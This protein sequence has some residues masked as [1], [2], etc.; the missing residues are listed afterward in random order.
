[1][2]DVPIT[3]SVYDFLLRLESKGLMEH[4]TLSKLPLQRKEII[5]ILKQVNNENKHFHFTK[6]E[7]ETANKYLFD[8]GYGDYSVVF[9]SETD[10]TQIF[11]KGLFDG[12]NKAFYRYNSRSLTTEVRPLAAIDYIN[13]TNADSS[14]YLIVGT[15]GLRWYGSFNDNFGFFLQATNGRDFSGD[16]SVAYGTEYMKSLKFAKLGSDIDLT[17]SHVTFESGWFRA[18]FGRQE[19]LSGAGLFQRPFVSTMSP[20]LD[21][22]SLS[23]NFSSF[24]YSY[25]FANLIGYATDTYST[26]FAAK[27]AQKYLVQHSFTAL[28]SW[29][30]I[31]FWESVIIADR[32]L[33]FAYLN[34]LSFLKSLEHQL[35]DRDNSL[36]GMDFVIRP[37]R[38]LQ[39]KSSFLLDDII[40]EKIGT[41]YWSNKT[42]FNIAAIT[43]LEFNTDI[44][45]EYARVEPY[46]Y[47]H[48]NHQNAYTNDSMMLGSFLLPNSEQ[49]GLLMQYWWGQKFPLKFKLTYTR[50][51]ENIYDPSGNLIRNV[52][53]DP[54]WGFR[55][56]NPDTG[57]QGDSPTVKFLDG[58]L[59]QTLAAEINFGYEVINNLA[60][61]LNYRYANCGCSDEHNFRFFV[62]LNEL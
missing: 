56:E 1:M 44:G 53:G 49:Y 50:H 34:P 7:I 41:G 48:F 23:A 45:V 54:R 14:K 10:S 52:G 32:G 47:T 46:T 33:D 31:T 9:P 12:T 35:H 2:D 26:G 40:M 28:P 19:E 4:N 22:L 37:I 24:R 57:F 43:S 15:L 51:G 59:I 36:M 6:S 55:F 16:R 21:E 3:S 18:K 11:F 13:Q 20:P 27:L 60:L 8:F 42:A 17:Q 39:I 25:S 29:G 38:N 30:E 5:K 61:F 62:Q 58:N